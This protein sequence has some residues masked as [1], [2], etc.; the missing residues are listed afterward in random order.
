MITHAKELAK[1]DQSIIRPNVVLLHPEII[2]IAVGSLSTLSPVSPKCILFMLKLKRTDI[3][4]HNII[5]HKFV[6]RHQPPSRYRHARMHTYTHTHACKHAHTCS[7]SLSHTHTHTHMDIYLR[8]AGDSW[9]C[10]IYLIVSFLHSLSL[11]SLLL[12]AC[13]HNNTALTDLITGSTGLIRQ[14]HCIFIVFLF[15]FPFSL[16]FPIF[17]IYP[18]QTMRDLSLSPSHP[19]CHSIYRHF[20]KQA[21]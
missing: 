1:A 20:V 6:I 5:L 15:A 19:R 9:K 21:K 7:L 12:W 8:Q 16:P 4:T 2:I 3:E 10:L 18:H 14:L 11:L 17:G 13:L